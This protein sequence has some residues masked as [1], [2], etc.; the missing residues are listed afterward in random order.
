MYEKLITKLIFKG[1]TIVADT[2][3]CNLAKPC[4]STLRVNSGPE[5]MPNSSTLV[6][7]LSQL[8][9]VG[10]ALQSTARSASMNHLYMDSFFLLLHVCCSADAFIQKKIKCEQR[11]FHQYGDYKEPAVRRSKVRGTGVQKIQVWGIPGGSKWWGGTEVVNEEE[12]IC[13]S[14]GRRTDRRWDEVSVL[15]LFLDLMLM[16]NVPGIGRS[17]LQNVIGAIPALKKSKKK[18][19][20]SHL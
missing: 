7:F 17:D 9:P 10:R 11:E 12:G 1:R 19:E 3:I 6:W 2:Y 18:K 13:V 15:V 5:E 8:F 16:M 14:T 20:E 4:S